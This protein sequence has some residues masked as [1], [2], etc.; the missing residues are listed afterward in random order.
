MILFD[1]LCLCDT[2]YCNVGLKK[3][4]KISTNEHRVKHF[5]ISISEILILR[6]IE[7]NVKHI[8][9]HTNLKLDGEV[10]IT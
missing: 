8:L 5:P 1:T 4:K 9:M 3:I 2:L 6:Y 10:E 7:N